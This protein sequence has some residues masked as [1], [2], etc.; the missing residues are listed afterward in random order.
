MFLCCALHSSSDLQAHQIGAHREGVLNKI[1]PTTRQVNRQTPPGEPSLAE[2]REYL[3]SR[4]TDPSDLE[5]EFF[6]EVPLQRQH[7]NNFDPLDTPLSS[8]S[9]RLLSPL[10]PNNHSPRSRTSSITL[11]LSPRIL[12]PTWPQKDFQLPPTRPPT[13][14]NIS[15]QPS[16]PATSPPISPID[17][18]PMAALFHMPARGER[19]APTFDKSKPRE[20]I[21]FFEELEYLFTR[22]ALTSESE[23]KKHVLRYVEF[24]VEQIWKTFPEYADATKHYADF[25]AA[26]LVHYPDASG[27]YVYSLRD[28]DLLIGERQRLGISTTTDLS[29]YHL[30]FISITSWLIEKKQLGT[31][32]QERGYLRAFQPRLLASINNR[33][34]M[35][36]P[37]KHPNIPHSVKDV[38]EAARFILQSAT[39]APQN[40]FAPTP[41]D[42][43]PPFVPDGTVSIAKRE[44]S[45]K[46]EDLGNILSEFT[47]TIVEAI[48]SNSRSRYPPN[49]TSSTSD[50]SSRACNFCGGPH[51]IRECLKVDELIREGKCKRNAEGK[52]VLPSGAFVPREIPGTLLS[53]R[54]E[55]W[56]RRYPNQTGDTASLLCTIDHPQL[57]FEKADQPSSSRIAQSFQL[58]TTDRIA[59][60]E[61]ELFS[62]RARGQKF[63][64][65]VRTR[66]QQA[67]AAIADEMEERE[68]PTQALRHPRIEEVPD[69]EDT[70]S[71]V[72]KEKAVVAEP[73]PV[74]PSVEAPEHPYQK[75]K[76]AAYTPPANRNIGA[77]VKAPA[78][79]KK[80]ETAYK[81]LPPVH[82]PAIAADVYKRSMD[83]S[84]TITQRELLSLSPEVRSQVR[85]VTT[86]R[87][88]PNNPNLP[89]QNLLQAEEDPVDGDILEIFS[90]EIVN[91]EALHMRQHCR[92]L[93]SPPPDAII[94]PDPIERYYRSLEPGEEPDIRCLEVAKDSFSIRA[95]SAIV[96]STRRHEC[97]VDPGCQII[98]MADDVCH[99]LALAYDPKIRLRMQSANGTLDWSLGIARNV[100]FTLGTITLYMQVHI[101]PNPAYDILLGRPFEV[102]TECVTRNYK[103]EDQTITITD[104]NT[105]QCSTIPTFPRGRK[106]RRILP[107]KDFHE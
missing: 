80:Q 74:T 89:S 44:P 105:G 91:S 9:D 54:I 25:K 85:D 5:G 88:I 10:V 39:T 79:A 15:D 101:I 71:T 45:I 27:D 36:F 98:A 19:S 7:L 93:P 49:S 48:Q 11:P 62:L 84:F 17:L 56:H 8:P 66:A 2:I 61:A 43:N 53:E 97:I 35:K 31:L 57:A 38:Y 106:L 76:D 100:P 64:P 12:Y 34:Q 37:D 16:E 18:Q 23:K 68:A 99:G 30:N 75:A 67:R 47:K 107:R 69:E 59:T 55:E 65:V 26:I 92:H 70:R 32:E 21:R 42:V 14:L 6:T 33:L 46:K 41:P 72:A 87:R 95:I 81:T 22:A 103:N 78:V 28:M 86:T 50:S 52:V 77:P 104:P 94:V 96:D 29:D 24:D 63:V 3:A 13:P 102:L 82:D 51:F 83:A 4:L 90:S 20:L 40:Y 73:T 60:I 1:A 58:S